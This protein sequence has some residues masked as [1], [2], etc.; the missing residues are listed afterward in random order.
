MCI[1]NLI[2]IAKLSSLEFTSIYPVTSNVQEYLLSPTYTNTMFYQSFW[3]LTRLCKKSLCCEAEINRNIVNQLYFN[4]IK[5][6]FVLSCFKKYLFMAA[7]GLSCSTQHLL[8][9]RTGFCLVVA[10][11]L[12]SCGAQAPE[13]TGSV[14]AVHGLSSCRVQA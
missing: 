13:H 10:R 4:K 3:F 11:G 2:N 7:L 12:S 14:V 9:C 1:Y 6:N 8:L 5:K